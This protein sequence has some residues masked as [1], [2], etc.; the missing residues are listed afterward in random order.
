MMMHLF[1][2]RVS[3]IITFILRG[4]SVLMIN[5][6]GKSNDRVERGV[7]PTIHRPQ[8]VNRHKHAVVLTGSWQDAT[9]K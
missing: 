2:V 3:L 6:F 8:L 1:A 7:S 9:M 4:A 5:V